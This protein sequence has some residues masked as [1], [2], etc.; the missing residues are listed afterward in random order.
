MTGKVVFD[1]STLVSAAIRPRS[2]PDQAVALALG[3]AQLCASIEIFEELQRVLQKPRFDLYVD[4]ES[5]TRFLEVFR[6]NAKFFA[7]SIQVQSEVAGSC[8]DAND[9]FILSL[10]M[11]VQAQ[12]IVSSD[13]DLLILNPWRG[14]PILT[15]AQFL[16]EAKS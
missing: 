3:R 12:V 4:R 5:R 11:T 15:P 7:V 13:H 10:A 8:R 9:D 14:I 6:Q 1:T 16:S 2:I